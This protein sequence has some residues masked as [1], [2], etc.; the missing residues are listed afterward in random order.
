MLGVMQQ[1]RDAVEQI[2]ASA[3]ST[4]LKKKRGSAGIAHRPGKTTGYRNAQVT[5]LHPPAPSPSP[6][7]ATP[8]H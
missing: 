2:Q 4:T 8:R 5:V 7:T 3:I 1:H 6:W